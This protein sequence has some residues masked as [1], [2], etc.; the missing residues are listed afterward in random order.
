MPKS[1]RL[2]LLLLFAF[3]SVVAFSQVSESDT[4]PAIE[5]EPLTEQQQSAEQSNN[6]QQIDPATLASALRSLSGKLRNEA[7]GWR[8]DSEELLKRAEE[9]QL[10]LN[11]AEAER[12][13]LSE[14]L[15]RST[16]SQELLKVAQAKE[17]AALQARMKAEAAAIEQERDQARRSAQLWKAAAIITAG[18]GA[19]FVIGGNKGVFFGVISSFLLYIFL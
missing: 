7:T 12:K 1:K 5:P 18:T 17:L 3:C 9:L 11:K 15:T 8:Q 14:S 4:P 16:E 2:S 13:L 19:G 6:P 10:L